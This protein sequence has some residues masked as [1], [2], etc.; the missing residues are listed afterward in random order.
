MMTAAAM[1]EKVHT[2]DPGTGRVLMIARG[3]GLRAFDFAHAMNDRTRQPWVYEAV[4]RRLVYDFLNGFNA[5]IIVYG[6]T[7][8][9]KT[10][11]MF[12]PPPPPPSK[13]ELEEKKQEADAKE[14]T[15]WEEDQAR[16]AAEGRQEMDEDKD[17]EA[18]EK[19]PEQGAFRTRGLA[20]HE[21]HWREMEEKALRAKAAREKREK[22]E[23]KASSL[24]RHRLRQRSM[25]RERGIVPRACEEIFACIRQRRA[26]GMR[27]DLTVSYVEIFGDEVIDLLRGGCRVGHSKVAAQRYVLSGA[28]AL[29]A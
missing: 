22:E 27:C 14:E 19:E 21:K 17:G 12:G 4:S 26:A 1:R 13:E 8:S 6:Q 5:T 11:T 29:H 2:V 16:Q 7:G 28:A 10:H 23:K 18:K 3:V 25:R 24:A 9:G 20:E 15:R